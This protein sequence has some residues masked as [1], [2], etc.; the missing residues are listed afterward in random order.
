[1]CGEWGGWCGRIVLYLGLVVGFGVLSLG[2][3]YNK[4]LMVMVYLVGGFWVFRNRFWEL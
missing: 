4:R 3:I 1:M 2:G